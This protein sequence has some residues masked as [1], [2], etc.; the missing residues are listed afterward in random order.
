M[1][2][3]NDDRKLGNMARV[4]ADVAAQA[5]EHQ[6]RRDE[7]A[8]PFNAE[9]VDCR[10]LWHVVT[11]VPNEER[12]A[13]AHLAGRRFGVYL[14]EYEGDVVRRGA[15]AHRVGLLLP[16]YI[17]LFVWD[18]E[19]HLRRIHA[20]PGVLRVVMAGSMPAVIEDKDIDKIRAAENEERPLRATV[21]VLTRRKGKRRHL[22]PTKREVIIGGD[23][24]VRMQCYSPFSEALRHP[25]AEVRVSAFHKAMGL[26]V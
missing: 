25:D 2:A 12:I 26:M 14:P 4:Y 1:L 11:A 8:G 15:K 19:R 17:F 20:C 24:I 6:R 10:P 3:P 9:L 22:R 21:E 16:G 7:R 23:E 13:A 5:L 18:I